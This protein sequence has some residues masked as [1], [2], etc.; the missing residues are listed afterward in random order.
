MAGHTTLTLG[1][2]D[3]PARVTLAKAAQANP[4]DGALCHD[5][6]NLAVELVHRTDVR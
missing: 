5:L 3:G 2:E 6:R 1:V 4:I